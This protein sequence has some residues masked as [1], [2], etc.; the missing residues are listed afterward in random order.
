MLTYCGVQPTAVLLAFVPAGVP[1]ETDDI[2]AVPTAVFVDIPTEYT[3]L[4]ETPVVNPELLATPLWL[5]PES[6]WVWLP[7]AVPVQVCVCAG[8]EVL[9]KI[10]ES[11]PPAPPPA[12]AT[13]LSI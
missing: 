8:T 10:G 6:V 3:P 2:F 5:C 1:A 4:T 11:V 9:F 7:N 12:V 13:T